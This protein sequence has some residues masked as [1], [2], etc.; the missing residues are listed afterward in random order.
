MHLLLF[1]RDNKTINY[2]STYI[3]KSKLLFKTKPQRRN[4][5]VTKPKL[6][7]IKTWKEKEE[8]YRLMKLRLLW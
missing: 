5:V 2:S 6:K 8:D 4:K 1:L 7:L 3:R